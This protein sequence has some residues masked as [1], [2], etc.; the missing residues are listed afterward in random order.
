MTPKTKSV[1]V[2]PSLLK[3]TTLRLTCTN[4]SHIPSPFLF[5]LRLTRHCQRTAGVSSPLVSTY[6]GPYLS[7]LT[8]V[9]LRTALL[10]IIRSHSDVSFGVMTGL[11][12]SP[13][14]SPPHHESLKVLYQ[15]TL[16]LACPWPTIGGCSSH[17]VV[18]SY[19][20]IYSTSCGEERGE[21]L[22]DPTPE[23]SLW[24]HYDSLI[25]YKEE[26]SLGRSTDR[27]SSTSYL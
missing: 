14:R 1:V 25:S 23:T 8:S 9:P 5:H 27:L 6:L 16:S 11:S 2:S 26:D 13:T 4:E 12:L 10:P 21:R 20:R 24:T 7:L 19:V 3:V 15:R 17:S 18:A 22:H